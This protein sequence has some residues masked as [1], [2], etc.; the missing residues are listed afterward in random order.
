[1]RRRYLD[2]FALTGFA[3][4]A[5]PAALWAHA[6][7]THSSP[8]ADARLAR[9][10]TQIELS[11]SESVQ[12]SRT[13][14]VLKDSA[15][16]VMRTGATARGTSGRNVRVPVQVPLGPGRYT[17]FWRNQALNDHPSSGSFAFRGLRPGERK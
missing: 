9:A 7:L 1:M 2:A 15:G 6:H 14:V 13:T 11:F 8:T 3:G 5:L 16:V 4:L 10:P 12:V 17:V